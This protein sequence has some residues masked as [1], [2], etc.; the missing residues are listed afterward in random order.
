MADIPAAMRLLDGL[1]R[2]HEP[3]CAAHHPPDCLCGNRCEKCG[4][5]AHNARI[6][7]LRALLGGER[8][9]ARVNCTVHCV[10][11]DVHVSDRKRSLWLPLWPG[12]AKGDPVSVVVMAKETK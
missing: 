9:V 11:R 10:E 1:R 4:A 6:E 12:A 2:E 7:E 8:E 5:S 3:W